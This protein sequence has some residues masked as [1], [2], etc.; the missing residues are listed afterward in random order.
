MSEADMKPGTTAPAID[1][2]LGLSVDPFAEGA[3]PDLFFVGGQRRFL[4]QQATHALYFAGSTVL[5][6][7]EPGAGKSRTL[8]EIRTGLAE[9]A[10]V[11]VIDASVMMDGAEIRQRLA[12]HCALPGEAVDSEAGLAEALQQLR[13]L[14]GE[15]APIVV[16]VDDAHV[17][18][19]ETL[20][21]L[22]RL[23]GIAGGRLRLLLAG[24]PSLRAAWLQQDDGSHTEQFE[25]PALDRQEIADY[26]QT[27][28]LAAGYRGVQPLTEPQLD[29]LCRSSRGLIGAIHQQAPALLCQ[30][31][32]PA[33]ARRGRFWPLP[34][35]YLAG[36]AALA[37]VVLLIALSE[38]EKKEV[39]ELVSADGSRRHVPL[40][41]TIGQPAGAAKESAIA[42]G[43]A[44]IDTAPAPAPA[45]VPAP[46]APAA[47]PA[48][49]P[50][51]KPAP[52]A[53]ARPAVAP[54]P[55]PSAT[56]ASAFA[57][58]EKKL[59]SMAGQQ[60]LVQL[61]GSHS[62]EKLTSFM[63]AEAKG[64]DILYFEARR[65]GKPWFV[66]VTGPF[67]DRAAVSRAVAGLPKTLR[68]L[69]PWQRTAASVQADIRAR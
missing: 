44:G 4:A 6:V 13:P 43:D 48:P 5:L 32:A 2:L 10:D 66:A 18:A 21:S 45:A 67:A 24:E 49:A 9:V 53:E 41:L 59:L 8:K 57:A 69:Q 58:S 19:A 31:A 55:R 23:V 37:V 64:V 52:T 17:L 56:P 15:P 51:A 12:R 26:L 60:Y 35:P 40:A 47:A 14:D 16:L 34:R 62:R 3:L 63:N 65:N 1:E 11:C 28:L 29:Q 7:G 22:R 68:D 36:A 39:N 50:A 25:L 61:M 46:S 42:A 27:R 20:A 30:T 33:P 54:A 38:G